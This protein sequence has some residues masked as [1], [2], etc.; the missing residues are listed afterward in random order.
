M[1]YDIHTAPLHGPGLTPAALGLVMRWRS[2][3]KGDDLNLELTIDLGCGRDELLA[4]SNAL[5][6][7]AVNARII[8]LTRQRSERNIFILSY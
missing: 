4:L 8:M 1:T 6:A 7:R 5:R 3:R 2:G